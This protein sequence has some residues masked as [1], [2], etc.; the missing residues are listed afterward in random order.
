MSTHDNAPPP[1]DWSCEP[2]PCELDWVHSK[3]FEDA[4]LKSA[5]EHTAIPPNVIL[6]DE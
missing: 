1:P 6:G 4:V 3:E 5:Q 2:R